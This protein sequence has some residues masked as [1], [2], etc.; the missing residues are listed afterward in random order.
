MA[1]IPFMKLADME[2]IKSNAKNYLP[3]FENKDNL[4]LDKILKHSPFGETKYELPDFAL[5]MPEEG[6]FS[7]ATDKKNVREC[8]K[9]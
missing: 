2:T 8:M 9:N 7:P 5:Y 1:K 6:K 4:W 3:Y